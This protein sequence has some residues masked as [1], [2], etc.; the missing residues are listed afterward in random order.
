MPK[1]FEDK[2][3]YPLPIECV[4]IAEWC[5][6]PNRENP[7]QVHLIIEIEEADFSMALRFKGTASLDKIIE[8]LLKS[9]R[10]VWPEAERI[11]EDR[12]PF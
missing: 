1:N 2:P 11:C 8:A 5:P 6:N 7:T 10:N 4:T 3:M 12:G 9:R